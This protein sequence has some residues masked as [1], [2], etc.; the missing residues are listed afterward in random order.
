MAC[1]GAANAT[2]DAQ[3]D[4][5][6][7]ATKAN[8]WY[9]EH[10]WIIGADCIPAY[11]VNQLKMWQAETFDAAAIDRELVLAERLGFNTLRVFPRNVVWKEDAS[12]F[13]QRIDRFLA[14]A[15]RHHLTRSRR[16]ICASC[17]C[18]KRSGVS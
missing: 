3:P 8:A 1:T 9:C 17:R 11:A 18:S 5:C 6:W 14:I 4:P 15:R 12:G 2:G 10:R 16:S 7:L 13:K